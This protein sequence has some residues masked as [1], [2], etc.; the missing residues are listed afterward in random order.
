[1]RAN[2]FACFGWAIAAPDQ[3][4]SEVRNP[5]IVALAGEQDVL[6]FDVAMNDPGGVCRVESARNL[7]GDLQNGIYGP[8]VDTQPIR[9]LRSPPSAMGITRN[10]FLS[11]APVSLS[12]NDQSDL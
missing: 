12:A 9:S 3:A 6:R 2:D 7:P 1:V 4:N 10:G 8:G 5:N 11:R